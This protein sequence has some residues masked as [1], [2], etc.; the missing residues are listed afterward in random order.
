[1]RFSDRAWHPKTG[2]GE[3]NYAG[4]V[5]QWCQTDSEKAYR[6]EGNSY[7]PDSFDYRYN[8]NGFRCDEFPEGDLPQTFRVLFAGCSFTM[9]VG[10]PLHELYAHLSIMKLR[11]DYGLPIPYWNVG[12][13]GASSDKIARFVT[14]GTQALQ[15]HVVFVLFPTNSR[16]EIC[17][18]DGEV[19]DFVPMIYPSI[20]KK[21]MTIYSKEGEYY[22]FVKN[23]IMIDVAC[24]IVGATF[25]WGSWAWEDEIEKFIPNNIL[26]KRSV[27]FPHNTMP[28]AR[29]LMHP[30]SES[31]FQYSVNVIEQLRPRLLDFIKAGNI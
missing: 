1:M 26:K 13:G 28:R 3:P 17:R 20:E 23:L 22:E 12:A 16:R 6:P 7:T 11:E 15:P 31:H 5:H 8:R 25:I 24:Q 2:L 14:F 18:K 21:V 10:L 4:Q 30:G 27:N 19:L 29:D 9:G